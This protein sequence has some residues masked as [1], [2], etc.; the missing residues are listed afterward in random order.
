MEDTDLYPYHVVSVG[1][2]KKKLESSDKLVFYSG[3]KF[4]PEITARFLDEALSDVDH[5]DSVEK[6]QEGEF[7]DSADARTAV[8]CNATTNSFLKQT[9]LKSKST[10]N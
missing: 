6:W 7:S 1:L 5:V 3:I 10:F 4:L 9:L 8:Q 2:R